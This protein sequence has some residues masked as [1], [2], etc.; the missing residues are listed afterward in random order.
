MDESG[1]WGKPVSTDREEIGLVR[2]Y[3]DPEYAKSRAAKSKPDSAAVPDEID[4]SE[5]KARR[6]VAYFVLGTILLVFLV[7][8][9]QA[10]LSLMESF[11]NLRGKDYSKKHTPVEILSLISG[12]LVGDLPASAHSPYM[13]SEGFG[14]VT[15][16]GRFSLAPKDFSE[17]CAKLEM[18][19]VE[20]LEPFPCPVPKDISA[21]W[22]P[23][24]NHVLVCKRREGKHSGNWVIADR[25]NSLI[26]ALEY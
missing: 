20:K 2:E 14:D 26:Y 10:Y 13:Y 8:G 11:N 12:R 23:P 16:W 17:F 19:E 15:F 9:I 18:K 3:D 6:R 24:V 21:W 5:R 7:L 22:Q 25:K 1:V 4:R